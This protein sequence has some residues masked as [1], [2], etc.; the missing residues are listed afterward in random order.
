M[1]LPGS[2]SELLQAVPAAKEVR[3]PLA[4]DRA[5]G[6]GGVHSHAAHRVG[7]RAAGAGTF[8]RRLRPLRK[9]PGG[10]VMF[11]GRGSRSAP[12]AGGASRSSLT[13]RTVV[14]GQGP[15][16]EEMS[17]RR[18]K[19]QDGRC[20]RWQL[21]ISRRSARSGPVAR[22]DQTGQFGPYR[23]QV[24]DFR[25][26]IS[27]QFRDRPSRGTSWRGRW[28]GRRERRAVP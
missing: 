1:Y 12:S 24:V 26:R 17:K 4:C 13:A 5:G 25:V 16:A 27:C 2:A 3:C 23:L 8:D 28:S 6:C 19:V 20:R 15:T 14:Q 7:D 22:G 18:S 9:I 21:G 11:A 10:R